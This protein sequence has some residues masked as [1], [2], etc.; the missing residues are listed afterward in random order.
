MLKYRMYIDE[1]GNSDLKSSENEL[2]RYL[3]LTGVI[4]DLK[5]SKNVLT[6]KLDN[7]KRKYFSIEYDEPIIFH[8]KEIINKKPPFDCLKKHEIE[9]SF[10]V[11][12]LQLFE[13][14]DFKV[15]TIVI[16]KLEHLN[17]YS[18][19]HYEPYHY[20]LAN[21]TE[22]YIR[23]LEGGGSVG[24]VMAESRGGREDRRLKDSFLR[25]FNRGTDYVAQDRFTKVLTSKQL[26]IKPKSSNIAALQIADL[27]AHP[28]RQ[29]IL[30]KNKKIIYSQEKF[31]QKIIK[32]LNDSKYD[33]SPAGKIDG[34]GRKLLP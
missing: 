34:Y 10:N 26:K 33:R 15:I 1:T 7:L 27:I 16:D 12:L 32:I 6:P 28:S 18:R 19:W 4:V 22:R 11:D 5:E 13:D 8:R 21:L 3:G 30:S 23:F 17:R 25:L 31:G 9:K 29:E 24:D 14:I 2:H 20:C